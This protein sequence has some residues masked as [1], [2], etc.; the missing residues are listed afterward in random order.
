MK[1][2]DLSILWASIPLP[3]LVIGADGT[4]LTLNPA[5]ENFCGAS[6]HRILGHALDGFVG[7]DSAINDILVQVRSGAVSVVQHN[8][9]MNWNDR[10]LGVC[11]VHAGRVQEG[12]GETLLLFSP[13]GVAEQMDR[14]LSHRSAARSVTGMA[15]ML[16]H[17][18]R[19]PLA[20]ISG[21]AQ[22]IAMG[23][24]EDQQELTDLIREETERIGKL[25][26]KVEDF[27]DPRPA[28]RVA[29]NIHDVIERTKRAA[30]AGYAAHVR[31]IEDYDPSLPPVAGDADQLVQVVQNLI[32]NAAEAVPE[33]GG[34]ITIRTKYRAGVKIALPGRR[35]ES[36]PLQL[37]ITDNGPGIP[38]TM[39]RDIFDPFVSSKAN[40][41]G[42]GLALVSKI[43]ADH[44]GVI[45]CNSAP[46]R[47]RFE[48]LMPAWNDRGDDRSGEAA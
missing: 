30:Q 17:E 39:V 29:V 9:S 44:G 34:T 48:L 36:L 11:T 23:P 7:R 31:F 2:P 14:S 8:I 10:D 22:L 15:A 33:A 18:I 35:R 1:V 43:V 4:I 32:K 6:R 42:L 46:G 13:R 19:T 38:E 26:E 25:V 41:T 27:G 24:G 45:R 5:A 3:V 37:S 20:G 21:A 40:G 16:A 12:T 47:T 28:E